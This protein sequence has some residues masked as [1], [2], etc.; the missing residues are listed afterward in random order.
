MRNVRRSVSIVLLTVGL[1]T[2][3]CAALIGLPDENSDEPTQGNQSDAS[4]DG[5]VSLQD[6]SDGGD[7]GKDVSIDTPDATE[8]GKDAL[9]Q[10]AD[11]TGMDA[12]DAFDGPTQEADAP[13]DALEQDTGPLGSGDILKLS[14]GIYHACVIRTDGDGGTRTDCWGKND[15]GELGRGS[16]TPTGGPAAVQQP[17]TSLPNRTFT[18]IAA[19]E[20]FTCAI[21]SAHD[22]Y[23]WG[24]NTAGQ[25]GIGMPPDYKVRPT[26]V[27]SLSTIQKIS[28][29]NT[30]ALAYDSNNATWW[31]GESLLDPGAAYEAT[32]IQ[33]TPIQVAPQLAPWKVLSSSGGHACALAA[34]GGE[35]RCWGR[36]TSLECT[37]DV[38]ACGV[39][40]PLPDGGGDT[41][42]CDKTPTVVAG[43]PTDVVELHAGY[44][45]TCILTQTKDVWC[46]GNSNN[47]QLGDRQD[48][49]VSACGAGGLGPDQVPNGV[50]FVAIAVGFE[51][52]CG[53]KS[54][55]GS[56]WCWGSSNYSTLGNNGGASKSPVPV[57][58]SGGTQLTG[59]DLISAKSAATCAA[60]KSPAA[61]YCWG[62]NGGNYSWMMD[63]SSADLPVATPIPL[64]SM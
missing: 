3:G 5:D 31:W 4:L 10:D 16:L 52:V 35:V 49:D 41:M 30:T 23:C 11:D 46:W 40:S 62:E 57:V 42:I 1:A 33:P 58:V 13:V 8:G 14:A 36:N 43:L 64:P 61:V 22:V 28:L 17:G 34:A 6:A 18:D 12:D 55:D 45:A 7:S 60:R 54:P 2:G 29:G 59:M 47:G 63:G 24:L 50:D 27:G 20:W 48:Q 32:I 37:T 44:S 51:Q 9:S 15:S 25:L 26:K 39:C 53:L 19:G 21:D 56:V 38:S